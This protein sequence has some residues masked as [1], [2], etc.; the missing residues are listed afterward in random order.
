MVMEGFQKIANC[1]TAGIV[2]AALI[3]GASTLMRVQISF[4]LWVILVW[5]PCFLATAA[6]GFYLFITILVQDYK[7][8]ENL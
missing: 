5:Q 1:I 3:M 7:G 6:G 4:R 8:R 2:L